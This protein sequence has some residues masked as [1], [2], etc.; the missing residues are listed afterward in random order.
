MTSVMK[1]FNAL[2]NEPISVEELRKY[3]IQKNFIRW[4]SFKPAMVFHLFDS[5]FIKKAKS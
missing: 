3:G 4:V 5:L 2:T 1:E